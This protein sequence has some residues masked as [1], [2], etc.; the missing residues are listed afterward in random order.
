[1][2]KVN[3]LIWESVEP[4][5]CVTACYGVLEV[6]SG[7]LTY[8]NAGHL[9]PAIIRKDS[10]IHLSK[11]GMLL[12]V[13]EDV[14]YEEDRIHLEGGDLLLFFTDGLTEAESPGGEP[15]GEDR[16]IEVA[17]A[18][19][20]LQCSAIAERIYEEISAFSEGTLFDDFTLL[21]LKRDKEDKH[22]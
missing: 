12:G 20:D 11:G 19:A 6:E 9:Y 15:F 22:V 17:R 16:L 5:R 8:S 4:E 21:V 14:T 18:S 2:H 1:M 7:V 13:L 10:T 3:R